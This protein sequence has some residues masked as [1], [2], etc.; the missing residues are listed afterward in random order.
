MDDALGAPGRADRLNRL[1]R[2]FDS[3]AIAGGWRGYAVALLAVAATAL[4]RA[5]LAVP[6]DAPAPAFILFLIPIIAVAFFLGTG[7]AVLSTFAGWLVAHYF[8]SVPANS[9]NTDAES[10][11]IFAFFNAEGLLLAWAGGQVR[12]LVTQL[13]DRDDRLAA[14]DERL[15]MAQAAARIATYEWDPG[16]RE[17]R[18]SENAEEIM[19]MVPGS[20]DN[21]FA[22]S[23]V[24]TVADD[25][26]LVETAMRDLLHS[27]SAE[28]VTRVLTPG[29]EM[30]W[31]RSTATLIRGEDG[32]PGR[33]VGVIIDITEQRRMLENEQRLYLEAKRAN[34]AKDEFLGMMSHEL[35]TPITVIHGGARVLKAHPAGLD[36]E[37]REGLLDDIERE[38]ERLSR[39][40]ENLLALARAELD[41]DVVLEP[42]LL[43][44][45]L[46]RLLESQG[47]A[48][49]PSI[50]LRD[51]GDAPAVAAEPGYIEHII[52]NL[53]SNARK[54]SPPDAPIEV[55]LAARDTAATVSVLDRGFGI[56]GDEANKIFERFYRSDRTARLA[57]GAGLGLAVCKR[58]VEAMSGEIWACP[59]AGGGLE[60]GFS[61][62]AYR[63]EQIEP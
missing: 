35:R 38:S 26:P 4:L 12:G 9:F 52:R 14:N 53:V 51:E 1:A 18:W 23:L 17:L 63:E 47:P 15:R 19:G 30:R 41:G 5:V 48:G 60:V 42:V 25:R 27:G 31:V 55:V 59:R 56:A 36:S 24:T 6:F 3:R 29:G 50:T 61:L 16:T 58:L 2:W 37:T 33:V 7:P 13:I 10:W 11:L 32:Q 20:F 43:Q 45:L 49:G 21:T 22:G 39:M 44:R 62:P 57:G 40:L 54:Y 34:D 46:P 28:L 8:F